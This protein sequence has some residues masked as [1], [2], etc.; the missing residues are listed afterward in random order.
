LMAL[1]SICVWCRWKNVAPFSDLHSRV[2]PQAPEIRTQPGKLWYLS[3]TH[4]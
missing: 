4:T 3:T 1:G 2:W